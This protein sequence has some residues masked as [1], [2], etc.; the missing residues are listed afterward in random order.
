M[1]KWTVEKDTMLVRFGGIVGYDFVAEHDLGMKGG[2][3]RYKELVK[4]GKAYYIALAR[5]AALDLEIA[6]SRKGN[7]FANDV[8]TD[9]RNFWYDTVAELHGGSE[10]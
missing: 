1:G 10:Q 8:L 3:K 4:T 9:E 5:L 2:K 7:S 6:Y